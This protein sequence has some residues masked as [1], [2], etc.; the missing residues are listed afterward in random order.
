[1][2]I[3]GA[4]TGLSGIRFLAGRSLRVEN[5]TIYSFLTHGIDVVHG[6]TTTPGE[7]TVKDTSFTNIGTVAVRIDNGAG[8]V[9]P[10]ATLDNVNINRA[11]IGFDVLKAAVGTITNS[12]VTH[13]TNQ[14]VVA[15]NTANV[16]AT[17]TTM[18]KNGTG[19]A[20]LNTAT[21]RIEDCQIVNNTTGAS[22]VVGAT[23][24]TFGN[25][26]IA[27]NGVNVSGTLTAAL[28]Q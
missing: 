15:E 6:S 16:N 19:I 5:C 20:A 2:S 3:N 13:V 27:G 12:V 11:L 22:I 23:G 25:N 18:A 9:A 14:A 28:L 17:H 21:F 7:L 26:V 4:G 10:S 8:A 1:L 24:N